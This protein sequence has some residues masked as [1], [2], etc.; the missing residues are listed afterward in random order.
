MRT[1][2]PPT[3]LEEDEIPD[4]DMD[5]LP[6]ASGSNDILP[7]S[8]AA[9]E[10]PAPASLATDAVA[11]PSKN[12]A[13]APKPP[14]QPKVKIPAKPRP[15][16][17][18]A[19]K[20][21]PGKLPP[22]AAIPPTAPDPSTSAAFAPDALPPTPDALLPTSAAFSPPPA[23]LPA[24]I[25][26]S[27]IELGAV[28]PP[29]VVV[30]PTVVVNKRPPRI[31][32]PPIDRGEKRK[33]VAPAHLALDAFALPVTTVKAKKGRPS[34]VVPP[35]PVPVQ[36]SATP[37]TRFPRKAVGKLLPSPP[38]PEFLDDDE[39]EYE[40]GPPRKRYK[41]KKTRLR[42]S[43][44]PIPSDLAEDESDLSS[45]AAD[46]FAPMDSDVVPPPYI[47]VASTSQQ[48][49]PLPAPKS[50]RSTK[51]KSLFIANP[52]TARRIVPVARKYAPAPPTS[53]VSEYNPF[54]LPPPISSNMQ[55]VSPNSA[56]VQ[57]EVKGFGHSNETVIAEMRRKA[58]E[59]EEQL[60]Q[61]R[62]TRRLAKMG[63]KRAAS[64]EEV[65]GML[66]SQIP[67]LNCES[68]GADERRTVVDLCV[69]CSA[70]TFHRSIARH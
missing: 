36:R 44:K 66:I 38:P 22:P 19:K 35:P 2:P 7:S 43:S 51:S 5:M 64:E 57:V 68:V 54:D 25:H 39:L 53:G 49:V 30:K 46:P 17:R 31:Y 42:R 18:P 34:N 67:C 61:E 6:F 47:P 48:E 13:K 58:K 24:G 37:D 3:I 55:S 4:F 26:I 23:D 56:L 1:A 62:E 21:G 69:D 29:P 33:R 50:H 59:L 41:T 70:F 60:E 63:K 12:P 28:N 14:A 65:I 20:K 10:V 8:N 9:P 16:G 40:H 15:P 52:P 45:L 11:S 32:N 27:Q